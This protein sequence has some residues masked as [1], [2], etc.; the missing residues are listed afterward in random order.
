MKRFQ[1]VV[2][3]LLLAALTLPAAAMAAPMITAEFQSTAEL[4]NSAQGDDGSYTQMYRQG[5]I[6][7]YCSREETFYMLEDALNEKLADWYSD[8]E[9]AAEVVDCEVDGVDAKRARMTLPRGEAPK[10]V[11]LYCL[12]DHDWLLCLEFTYPA[13]Q[14]ETAAAQVESWIDSVNLVDGNIDASDL[15]WEEVS[16]YL[17]VFNTESFP[18][19]ADLI[20][21]LQPTGYAWKHGSEGV[22][23]TLSVP[24][25]MVTVLAQGAESILADDVMDAAELPAQAAALPYALRQLIW[26]S[27]EFPFDPPRSFY[28]GS[29][30]QTLLDSFP[31]SMIEMV[32]NSQYGFT[33]CIELSVRNPENDAQ[34]VKLAFYG[35]DTSVGQVVLDVV[36][37]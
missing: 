17:E 29:E 10:Q 16:M 19:I 13:A 18:T 34:R 7:V 5:D 35:A 32:S 26:V 3:C 37:K 15:A 6:A 24:G 8:A 36:E 4:L 25:G 28:P 14:A 9:E 22:A 2:L 11:D 30:V 23:V 27:N 21:W 1:A 31:D 33:Q 20:E 12:I